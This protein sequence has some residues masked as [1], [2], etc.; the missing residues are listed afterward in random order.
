MNKKKERMETY[1][2]NCNK[3]LDIRQQTFCSHKCNLEYNHNKYIANWK[4]GMET[5]LRGKY[6]ISQYISRYLR[7]KYDNKCSKC[8][9]GEINLYTNKV[10]LEV[11]H[12]DGNYLNNDEDNLDLICPNCHSLT[13]TYKGANVGKGR[14]ERSKYSTNE[15]FIKKEKN[16]FIV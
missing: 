5:G 4:N 14:K 3:I 1:C 11:E 7:I 2:I 10:P 12:I 9:W 13:P 8:G 15:Q 16:I 6:S